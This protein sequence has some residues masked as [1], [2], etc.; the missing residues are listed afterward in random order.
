MLVSM[1]K[2]TNM[3]PHVYIY[4]KYLESL[5]AINSVKN[6]KKYTFAPKIIPELMFYSLY[7]PMS[8]LVYS[9]FRNFKTFI[10]DISHI[11]AQ[12][13]IFSN[14]IDV[15]YYFISN[16]IHLCLTVTLLFIVFNF[17]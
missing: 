9:I 1:L 17:L 4:T 11:I 13:Y 14:L 2:S 7:K 8:S 12:N 3:E 10:F 16:I 5:F 15:F 6:V